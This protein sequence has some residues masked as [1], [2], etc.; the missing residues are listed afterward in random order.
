M[1][2]GW[3]GASIPLL[4]GKTS[5]RKFFKMSENHV[6]K[7]FLFFLEKAV[8]KN[9][10]TRNFSGPKAGG[11]TFGFKWTWAVL[12]G[13]WGVEPPPLPLLELTQYL[14]GC[15][16]EL[17]R[18]SR[19]RVWEFQVS[20]HQPLRTHVSHNVFLVSFLKCKK[21]SISAEGVG[22]GI[23]LCVNSGGKKTDCS[24][25]GSKEW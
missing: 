21:N 19:R 15:K 13:P 12:R 1:R 3:S 25:S 18:R 17:R 9:I 20:T 7:C 14:G 23:C 24:S 6:F 11:K 10:K 5:T 16:W 2:E 22:M 8:K 4:G